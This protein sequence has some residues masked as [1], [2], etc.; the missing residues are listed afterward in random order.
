M[1]GRL[2]GCATG[3]LRPVGV[4]ALLCV[5]ALAGC[6]GGSGSGGSGSGDPVVVFAAAS[7]KSSF[8]QLGEDFTRETGVRVEFSFGGSSGL[9]QQVRAGAPA[10]VL[11]LADERTMQVAADAE[12]VSQSRVFATN[13]LTIAVP[14]GN[15]AGVTGLDSLT[16]EGTSVA[17]CAPEV[18]CGNATQRV[19][20]LAGVQVTPATEESKVSAVLTKVATGQVD[21]GLVYVTDVQGAVPGPGGAATVEAVDFPQATQAVNRYPIAVTAQAGDNAEVAA[22]FVSYVLSPDGQQVL[23]EAG[24][25]SP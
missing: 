17:V 4:L 10:Q 5:V 21:A 9:V 6:A 25:G 19:L 3:V 18:P 12:L 20:Q 16:G 11:A 15:P 24:F 14:A 7:L 1:V 2:R 22:T 8:E 23:R 13:T